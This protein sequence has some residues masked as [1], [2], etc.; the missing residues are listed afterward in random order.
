V[1]V[2]V[3]G[4]F[5]LGHRGTSSATPQRAEQGDQNE[6]ISWE[7]AGAQPVPVSSAHGP[8]MISNGLASGFSD[9]E[10]G[11]VIAAINIDARL[12]PALG[13][14]VYEPTL[15]Q[16]CVGDINGVL[17]ALPTVVR[18][19]TP[20]STFP[21]QYY[22]KIIDGSVAASALDVSIV[23]ATPQTTQLGGYAELTRTI[24]WYEGDWKLQVPTPRPRIINSTDGYTPLGGQ[25]HA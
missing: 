14:A 25:P 4:A 17:Q 9:D 8:R 15:R 1:A 19:G 21:T 5:I 13:P 18:Q 3:A 20:D 22:Y 7:M 16:Q 24:Y 10:L 23:A 6:S 11:A 12:S 2:I